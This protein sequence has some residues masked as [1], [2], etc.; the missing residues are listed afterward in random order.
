IA[1]TQILG[2]RQSA[3][4][5]AIA[6]GALAIHLSETAASVYPTLPANVRELFDDPAVQTIFM[7][8]CGA[9]INLPWELVWIPG[10]GQYLGLSHVL[11]R[12]HGLGELASVLERQPFSGRPRAVVVGNPL[13]TTADPLENARLAAKSLAKRLDDRGFL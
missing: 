10:R 13:H 1:A 7:A 2:K 9:T 4:P 6:M 8:P 12:T 3:E 11:P 5:A